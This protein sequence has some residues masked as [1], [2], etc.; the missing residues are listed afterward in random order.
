MSKHTQRSIAHL[1]KLGWVVASVEKWLPPRGEMK[2]GVRQDVFGFGDLL[3]CHPVEKKI[4]LVQVTA[5]SGG[6]FMQHWRKIAGEPRA[7]LWKQSGGQIYLHGWAKR[8]ERGKRKVWTLR[9][10]IL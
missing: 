3:A 4:A 1:K 2:F 9:E 5:S 7:A 10:E 8:G 6:V